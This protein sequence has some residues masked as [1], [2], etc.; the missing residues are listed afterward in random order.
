MSVEDLRLVE[1]LRSG[2]EDAFMALVDRY[3]PAMLRIARMYVSTLAVAEEVVQDT[4][5]GVLRG[6]GGFE[7]RSSLRTWIFRILVN[8]AKTRGRREARSVP[9]SSLWT[10]DEHEES[11]DPAR[12]RP[13]DDPVAPGHWLS[14]PV[15][16]DQIP[17]ERLLA[18]ETLRQVEMAIETLPPNQRAVIR[19]R[20]LQGWTSAE[21]CNA[22]DIGETNQ[23]VLLHRARSKVRRALERYLAQ[24]GAG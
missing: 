11:V 18:A 16:W 9:F 17:E 23:R 1:R 6:L 10:P 4:W 5:L 22:L 14:S 19:L 24:E 3:R 21:V 15:A 12:F 8:T 20:D 2:D 7:G 13:V